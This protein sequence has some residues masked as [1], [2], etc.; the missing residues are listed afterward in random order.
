MVENRER[1]REKGSAGQNRCRRHIA[2]TSGEQKGQKRTERKN[3]AGKRGQG[4]GQ[5]GWKQGQ[6][7][8]SGTRCTESETGRQGLWN[9]F[10]QRRM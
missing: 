9:G 8:D 2:V 1:E 7:Q 5:R 6:G 10:V 4:V 3:R